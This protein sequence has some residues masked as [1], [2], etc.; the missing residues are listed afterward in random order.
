MVGDQLRITQVLVNF[1]SNAVKFTSQGEISVT[2][3]QMM[4]SDDTV[5]FMV[6]VKDTGTGMDPK[7]INS[8]FRP[9]QQEDASIAKRF[10]GSGLGATAPIKTISTPCHDQEQALSIDL[11]PMSVMVYRCIRRSPVRKKKAGEKAPEKKSFPK[12]GAG[13]TASA[14]TAARRSKAAARPGRKPKPDQA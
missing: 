7:F 10:G 8:I 4:L 13:K 14:K 11:P 6:A 3:R 9:F 2:F 12:T 5:S 1:L